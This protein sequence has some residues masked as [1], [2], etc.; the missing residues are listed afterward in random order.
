M[1]SV[2][3]VSCV[4]FNMAAIIGWCNKFVYGACDDNLEENLLHNVHSVLSNR[5]NHIAGQVVDSIIG[6]EGDFVV[7]GSANETSIQCYKNVD[8]VMDNVACYAKGGDVDVLYVDVA[9]K[10]KWAITENLQGYSKTAGIP[11]EIATANLIT[12]AMHI[13]ACAAKL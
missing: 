12:I 6:T 1:C 11:R 7:I 2:Y 4:R 13:D 9:E 3:I 5:M 10:I 8:Y